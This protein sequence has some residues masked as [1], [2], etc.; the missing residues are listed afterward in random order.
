MCAVFI[1]IIFAATAESASGTAIYTPQPTFPLSGSASAISYNSTGST[2]YIA[3]G[4]GC[5]V[6]TV[7]TSTQQV[8]QSV[9]ISCGISGSIEDMKLQPNSSKLW[10]S[11]G[12]KVFTIDVSSPVQIPVEVTGFSGNP[13]N[14]SFSTDGLILYIADLTGLAKSYST[15]LGS[16]STP[17]SPLCTYNLG[18]AG[19]AVTADVSPDGTR[20][21]ATTAGPGSSIVIFEL[22]PNIC[23]LNR[24]TSTVTGTTRSAVWTA[25]SSHVFVGFGVATSPVTNFGVRY[26]DR[27]GNSASTLS[28]TGLPYSLSLSPDGSTILTAQSDSR[29]G[30][31]NVSDAS[32]S[33]QALTYF[34]ESSVAA[35]NPTG[36]F[37][38]L[39]NSSTTSVLPLLINP[40]VGP[41]TPTP[42]PSHTTLPNTGMNSQSFETGF[43][44]AGGMLI[45]G[46][47]L[48]FSSIFVA[49]HRVNSR[50]KPL[51]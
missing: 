42:S 24:W 18:T 14:F 36:S 5:T 12:S 17:I 46:S 2:A 50:T 7:D 34:T 38:Y 35:F 11:T 15:V 32:V 51:N 10:I 3:T 22:V 33:S 13:G 31:I 27:D 37:A 16:P 9:S 23:Y 30:L 47:V 43:F 20:L 41:G 4:S 21:L 6:L 25:D 49:R 26:L 48:V 45:F 29:F 39:G 19:N 44:V 40:P 28:T 8:T 1:S